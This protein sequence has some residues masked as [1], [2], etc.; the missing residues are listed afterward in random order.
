MS[1]KQQDNRDQSTVYRSWTLVQNTVD[2][3][4][5]QIDMFLMDI[6]SPRFGKFSV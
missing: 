5:E 2:S 1:P 4:A 3:V 6:S